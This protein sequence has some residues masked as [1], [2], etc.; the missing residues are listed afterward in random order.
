MGLLSI[1]WGCHLVPE[2]LD[3]LLD[4]LEQGA[5]FKYLYF[6]GHTPTVAGKVDKSCFSQ[7]F[8]SPF[9]ADGI[10]YATAEHYMMAAKARLFED[11]HHLQKILECEHPGEAKKLGRNVENFQ[12]EVW[13]Q[14]RTNIVRQ[15]N[16]HKFSQHAAL[17]QYL[18]DTG[19]RILV[20]ASPRDR[21]WGIGMGASNADAGDPRRWRGLNLLGFA[22]MAARESLRR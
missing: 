22:L 4:A 2:N 20:E 9:E 11:T 6:W 14:H 8:A 21:I 13:A 7:W 16:V 5:S 10:H 12:P 19:E 1:I 15:A 18:L 3:Q 17:G